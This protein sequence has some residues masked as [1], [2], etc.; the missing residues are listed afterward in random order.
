MR[1]AA[2][3]SLLLL[4]S[5]AAPDV[6]RRYMVTSFERVRVNGPF[7]IEI[8][9]G[10]NSASA[11]GMADAIER[12]SLRVS[13]NTLVINSGTPAWGRRAQD[14]PEALRIRIAAPV[15][16]GLS[17]SGG[18]QIRVAEM[19]AARVDLALEGS[20]A[21]DVAGIR[22]DELHA[23]HNGTGTL[24]LAGSAV[25]ARVRGTLAGTVD[26]SAFMANDAILLWESRAPLTI[27]V[28]YTAQI[29]ASGLGPVTILGKPFCS[30]RGAAPVTC[31]GTIQRR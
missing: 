11:K 21:I 2:L 14:A 20:S 22:A 10:T 12:L 9:T 31:A 1:L 19:R 5:A 27:G 25:T 29:T 4:T 23:A 13:G 6:E 18:A 15:L 24:K 3:T 17:A 8:I 26:A 30:I 28:R 16:K 7:E